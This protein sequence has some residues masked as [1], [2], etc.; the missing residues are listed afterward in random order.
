[1]NADNYWYRPVEIHQLAIRPSDFFT[2]NPAI[3]VPSNRNE[4]SVLT[5]GAINGDTNGSSCCR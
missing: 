1:M 2:E 5:N 3:D 4:A